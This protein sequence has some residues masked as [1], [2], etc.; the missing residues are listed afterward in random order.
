[1]RHPIRTKAIFGLVLA[2]AMLS[3]TATAHAAKPPPVVS[4]VDSALSYLR[5][6][7]TASGLVDSYAE[8]AVDY[9]YTYDNALAAMAFISAGDHASAQRILDAFNSMPAEPGGGFLHRYSATTKLPVEGILYGGPNA[10]LLQAMNLYFLQTGD[11]R[12]N[13]L[14]Q[15]LGNFLLTLQD[16]DGGLFGRPAVTWKSAENNMGA[17]SALHNLGKVQNIPLYIDQSAMIRNFLVTEC[18]DG[19]RFFQ[20]END[21]TIVTDV[22]A[23]GA[24]VMGPG[25]TNGAFWAEGQTLTTKTYNGRKRVTGFDFDA[26]R[27]MVWTEGTL[28]ESLAFLAAGDLVKSNTYKAESEKLQHGSGGFWAVSN[29]G[30]AG[31]EIIQKWK[32]VAAT[33]WYVYAANQDNVLELLP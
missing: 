30:T 16:A 13:A 1:M 32:A 4:K 23:L 22:Q 5:S 7:I 20:G 19:V 15:Q 10:Y 29:P 11:N 25:Y 2:A 26:D 33:A 6:R 21:P 17:L 12:Y 8:D 14:A 24:L 27:D 3:A 31:P 18:W 28:Q 9:S